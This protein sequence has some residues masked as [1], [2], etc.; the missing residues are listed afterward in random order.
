M[1]SLYNIA[2]EYL[3]LISEL[4]EN[5]GE[6]TPELEE[7]LKINA[8][9]LE[10]KCTN[11]HYIINMLKTNVEM[12][13]REIARIQNFKNTKLKNIEKLEENLLQALLI[14]GKEDKLSPK[15]KEAG[16]KP[17]KR[18]EF[19]TLRLSTRRSTSTEIY[20]AALV[21]DKYKYCSLTVKKISTKRLNALLELVR[22]E[23]ETH[24]NIVTEQEPSKTLIRE[25]LD[26]GKEVQGAMLKDSY[27][28]VIK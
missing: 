10:R 3:T 15:D 20:N 18:L 14:F 27:S 26:Q 2:E 4:E 6:L 28:L 7:A 25:D 5:G 21:D 16:K 12:A 17:V 9:E 19:G 1:N 23:T 22:K 11:Y 24:E 13:D 8:N